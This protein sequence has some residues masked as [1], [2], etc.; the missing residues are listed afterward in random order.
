MKIALAGKVLWISALAGFMLADST[1]AAAPSIEEFL[2]YTPVQPGVD[3]DRPRP[4][5]VAKC[6]V[7][8]VDGRRWVVLSPDG[9]V[10]REFVDTS[11][12]RRVDQWSYYKDGLEVYRDL[13]SHHNG[14]PDQ[15]RWFNTG[16]TRW[17]IENDDGVIQSWKSIS[18]EEVAA[19]VVAAI[20]TQDVDRFARL[21]LTPEELKSLGLGKS[22]L[23]AVGGKIGKLIGGF[24]AM[25]SRQQTITP[26]SVCVQFSGGRPGIVPAGTDGSTK[27]LRVYENA[28]AIVETG[29]K[30]SQVQLG[31]L[32]RVGDA[33]RLIDLPQPV[34]EGQANAAP[35][36]LF[37]QPAM[38][39]RDQRTAAA[40]P[41]D[42]F[43]KL[44]GDLEALD[45][46]NGKS[47]PSTPAEQAAVTTKR[48]A[49]LERIAA[50]ARNADDRAVW[51][52]QLADMILAAVQSGAYPEGKERLSRLLEKLRASDADKNLAAYV[53]L[54]QLTAAYTLSW[55]APKADFSKIQAEWLKSLE[56]YVND[57]PTASETPEAMLQ[58]GSAQELTGQ[59]EQARKWYGRI[60]KEFPDS[61]AARKASGAQLRLDSV[62]KVI[63]LSG[64]SP[65]GGPVD[66]GEFRGKVVL[67]QYW[68]TW[69]VPAKNDMAAL[70]ELANKY[71]DSFVV[72]GVSLDNSLKGLNA[73]LAENPLPWPQIYEDGGMDSRPA[74]ALGI[75]TVPTMILVDQQGKVVN[76]N[77]SMGELETELK[78]LTH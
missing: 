36:G 20:A 65:A 9:L 78:R 41:S 19:E 64:K 6:K 46:V 32:I 56:Q 17:G 71:R 53:R 51:I 1:Q 16:G 15:C 44:L 43:Q 7:K 30:H 70:K 49:L 3:Y 69:S 2:K 21:V 12:G 13:D 39:S 73:Y 45:G 57:Y 31:T 74:N 77:V 26:H 4:E 27:D 42:A 62:G 48:A 37:F 60:V 75:L 47:P 61:P 23:E 50:A 59:D 68:A 67:I 66:L 38:P 55:Q 24:K 29:E 5:N 8:L 34:V 58:L 35:S 72:I 63:T 76:R 18:A 25:A 54:R 28:M 52:R 40:G 11:G 10:L 14:R 33:W 22:R